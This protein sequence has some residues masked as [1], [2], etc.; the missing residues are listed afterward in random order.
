M[1]E[2][3]C[4]EERTSLGSRRRSRSGT[5][6]ARLQPSCS[7]FVS[8]R[9]PAQTHRSNRGPLRAI[10]VDVIEEEYF[11]GRAM[12]SISLGMSPPTN[13]VRFSTSIRLMRGEAYDAWYL[14]NI[15]S[16]HND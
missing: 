5:P 3:R 8:P 10:L 15:A 13:P 4:A 1:P 16:A 9:T 12:G 6:S 2:R 14:T 7:Y 11:L